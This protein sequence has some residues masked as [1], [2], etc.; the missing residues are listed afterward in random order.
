VVDVSF[1]L[2]PG[3]PDVNLGRLG[4]GPMIGISPVLNRN[5]TDKLIS[6]AEEK[7]MPWTREI[8][9]SRTGT[10]SDGVA[11]TGRGVP[12]GLVSVPLRY[13]HTPQRLWI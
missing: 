3:I 11:T 9:G 4:G 8:M 13:M 1:A 2:Q 5:I 12:T 10:N 6:L 7:K